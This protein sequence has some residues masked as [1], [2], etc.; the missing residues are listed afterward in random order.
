MGNLARRISVAVASVGM[1]VVAT[2][3]LGASPA[4]AATG[5]ARCPSGYFCIFDGA[6][7]TGKM[8]YFKW[9]SPD[10]RAQGMHNKTTSYWNRTSRYWTMYD[11]FKY[12]AGGIVGATAGWRST[13]PSSYFANN[14][15]SSLRAE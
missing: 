5:W 12:T 2:I 3:A 14:R 4:Q 15:A 13:I 10:L 9:G 1:A 6:S 7:G 8:A 11:G